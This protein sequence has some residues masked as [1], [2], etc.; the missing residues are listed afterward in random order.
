MLQDVRLAEEAHGVAQ[1]RPEAEGDAGGR[2]EGRVE[3]VEVAVVEVDRGVG[4]AH[5]PVEVLA[6][7][8]QPVV[9]ACTE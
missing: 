2:G 6:E 7:H 9:G 3:A 5:Q 1:A 4:G 8:L